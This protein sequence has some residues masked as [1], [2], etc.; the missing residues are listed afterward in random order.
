[1]THRLS[2]PLSTVAA[3]ALLA[4]SLAA[5][6]QDDG[7]DTPTGPGKATASSSASAE[8][9]ISYDQYDLTDTKGLYA[10]AAENLSAVSDVS[11]SVAG[12]GESQVY[13]F[14]GEDVSTKILSS[15]GAM[16]E[17]LVVD[18]RL[19]VKAPA[20]WWD[21]RLLVN[22]K[23]ARLMAGKWIG[24]SKGSKDVPQIVTRDQVLEMVTEGLRKARAT[25]TKE[26]MTE[27]DFEGSPAL[28]NEG[29]TGRVVLAGDPLLPV[30]VGPRDGGD[31]TITF[32]YDV[33]PLTAPTDVVLYEDIMRESLG[34]DDLSDL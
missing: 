29:Q 2:R 33:E 9:T 18:G 28:L 20:R 23:D 32:S 21:E 8:P 14:T 27:I 11:L 31:G 3:A 16:V 13:V 5:C 22:A 17:T 15:D 10:E 26:P 6:G 4:A 19:Y 25:E 34:L 7:A 1:V 12:P 24:Y 30:T